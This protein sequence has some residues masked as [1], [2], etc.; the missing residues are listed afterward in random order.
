MSDPQLHIRPR[1]A[2][3]N[4]HQMTIR[5]STRRGPKRSPR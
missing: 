1:A 5:S 3:Q 4:D 2:V